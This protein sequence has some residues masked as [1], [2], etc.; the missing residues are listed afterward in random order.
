[1]PSNR[2]PTTFVYP[3]LVPD[4]ET[5]AYAVPTGKLAVVRCVMLN[6]LNE[7]DRLIVGVAGTANGERVQSFDSV[8]SA[9]QTFWLYL[10][11]AADEEL[12][13]QTDSGTNI[14][15]TITG[16]LLDE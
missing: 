9:S 10:P 6:N 11:L 4:T 16:D 14:V 2:T 12:Y 5:L 7:D 15:A 8:G 13:Y 3:T 1:M